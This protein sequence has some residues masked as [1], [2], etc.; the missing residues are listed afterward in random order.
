MELILQVLEL[1][2]VMK[3]VQIRY[4]QHFIQMNYYYCGK[5]YLDNAF[6]F[7]SFTAK[8]N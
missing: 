3:V 6:N 2:F 8:N 4:V 7:Y 1:V 5:I